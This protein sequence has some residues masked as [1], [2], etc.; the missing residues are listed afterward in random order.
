MNAKGLDMNAI[1]GMLTVPEI[2]K[3][4]SELTRMNGT[5][6]ERIRY[7]ER[8]IA[9]RDMLTWQNDLA[10]AEQRAASAEQARDNAERVAANAEQVAAAARQEVANA[11]K[12][13]QEGAQRTEALM[14]SKGNLIGQ[15]QELERLRHL[16]PKDLTHLLSLSE[17][18]LRRCLDDLKSLREETP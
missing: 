5:Q 3:A 17:D 9:L 18:Q 10:N 8:E 12:M 15:I 1:P 13:L 6:E 11:I 14:I 4:L 2:K 7:I 16:A